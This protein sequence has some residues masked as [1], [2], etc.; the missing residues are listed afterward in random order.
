MA[1]RGMGEYGLYPAGQRFK[2]RLIKERLDEP[3]DVITPA[4]IFTVSM[5]DLFGEWVPREWIDKVIITTALVGWHTFIFLT[6]NP[7]KYADFKFPSNVWIGASADN[8]TDAHCRSEH[9]LFSNASVKWM[10]LE[11]LLDDV[12][13]YINWDALN[14]VVVGGQ[15]GPGAVQPRKEWVEKII[16]KAREYRIPIFLK[17]NLNWPEKIQEFPM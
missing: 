2:P 9:L 3:L 13:E 4:K 14:W 16:A 17:D 10:S 8:A 12:A 6:K 1:E 15:T 11:P 5:G 7:I